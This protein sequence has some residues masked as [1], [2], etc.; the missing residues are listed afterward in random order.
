VHPP[1][2]LL[3]PVTWQRNPATPT[4]LA[5]R[6]GRAATTH[7]LAARTAT[8][9]RN[10]C[11]T[12]PTAR[13]GRAA[14]KPG[15]STWLAAGP[16]PRSHA[17]VL[18]PRSPLGLAA[19]PWNRVHPPGSLFGSAVRRDGR[20]QPAGSPLG[21]AARLRN[22]THPPGLLLVLTCATTAHMP[23]P[24]RH[25]DWPR[26]H[27]TGPSTCLAVRIGRVARWPSPPT[28]LAA[29]PTRAATAPRA[30][31]RLVA[32]AGPAAR[33]PGPRT[34][35]GARPNPWGHGAQ[36]HQIRFVVVAAPLR[37]PVHPP[38]SPR[39]LAARGDMTQ[40]HPLVPFQPSCSA[41]PGLPQDS[42]H[43]IHPTCADP[44]PA[45]P[46]ARPAQASPPGD[47]ARPLRPHRPYLI[48]PARRPPCRTS[49]PGTPTP[50]TGRNRRNDTKP[51]LRATCE[52]CE[53]P[54][55][56]ERD[57]SPLRPPNLHRGPTAFHTDPPRPTRKQTLRTHSAN[58]SVSMSES[59]QKQV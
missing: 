42:P 59:I 24:A 27:G 29:G 43:V 37:D 53:R 45:V 21:P 20:V 14:T 10:R 6:V 47:L 49:H 18:L 16:N 11:T 33:N 26:G 19:R 23:L 35:L 52:P 55:P 30:P 57:S 1:G 12:R 15:P 46:S 40:V 28:W 48:A 54:N 3:G 44:V 58:N 9:L 31:I 7:L 41:P 39:D 36:V 34:W 51:Q 13:T 2:L 25:S 5:A 50:S 38:D 8:R 56:S 22:Q 17:H 4:W 32:R